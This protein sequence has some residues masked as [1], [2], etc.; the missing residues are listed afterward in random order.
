LIY[1]ERTD[2]IKSRREGRRRCYFNN[3]GSPLEHHYP[4]PN[5]PQ[6]ASELNTL[7]KNQQR[8]LNMICDRPGIGRKELIDRSKLNRKTI[9]YNLERLLDQK[10]IWK[11]KIEDEIGYEYI[12]KE[13]L[14][15]EIYNR[16]LMKLLADE[17]DEE[18]FHKIK[19]K[20][21]TLDV[22]EIQL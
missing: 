1:L 3:N 15:N 5:H 2:S 13:K 17:I 22:D 7:T 14:R 10:L 9:S 18:T 20:L 4:H 8:I 16:L 21:E 19:M 12:T 11:V 6:Q